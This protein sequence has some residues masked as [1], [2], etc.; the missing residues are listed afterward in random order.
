MASPK[1]LQRH[2]K[3]A[4]S[5]KFGGAFSAVLAPATARLDRARC[6]RGKKGAK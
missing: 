2:G 4:R 6:S 3:P 1:I 5:V